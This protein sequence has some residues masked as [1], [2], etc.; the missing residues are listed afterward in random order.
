M[1][2]AVP[3]AL[4]GERLDRVVAM[5][6]G[7][8]RSQVHQLLAA[9]LVT[10]DGRAESRPGRRVAAGQLV[11]A[12]DGT[13]VVDSA[14]QPE[15][16]IPFD[17]VHE[18]DWLLVVDKPAGLVVHPGAGAPTGTLVNGLLARYPELAGVGDPSRPGIV[19]R[20]DKG[21][22]GLMAVARIPAAYD[23]LTA[24]LAAREVTRIYTALVH[25]QPASDRGTVD[26]PIGRSARQPTR[27]AVSATGRDARTSYLVLERFPPAGLTLLE[28]SLE[29]GRTHQIRVHLSA[30]GHPVLGDAQYRGSVR[31]ITA[32][33]GLDRP[34]LHARR[35]RL[36]HPSGAGGI[37]IESPLPPDL[38]SVLA[39]L[40]AGG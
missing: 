1:R 30:I 6:T 7:L 13:T 8:P 38:E 15:P 12:P 20:L 4:A 23:R 3:A 37:D 5:A 27:M 18:D 26:A 34:F 25:G 16:G 32:S 11:E 39:D 17:V 19:H 21:T 35:L 2:E 10:L 28:C 33:R 9:G 31:S 36:A 40:R 22:S 29:T 24:M 14:P